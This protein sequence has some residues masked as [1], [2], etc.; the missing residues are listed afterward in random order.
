[1]DIDD[2][3]FE[4]EDTFVAMDIVVRDFYLTLKMLINHQLLNNLEDLDIRV[5]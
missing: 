1:M 2:V 5:K 3:V 4:D